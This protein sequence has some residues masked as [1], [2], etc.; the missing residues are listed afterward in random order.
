MHTNTHTP[1]LCQLQASVLHLPYYVDIP[2]P[3]STGAHLSV[4]TFYIEQ[5]TLDDVRRTG[6]PYNMLSCSG[7]AGPFFYL[8]RDTR[9][10]CETMSE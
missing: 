5:N 8:V 2:T 7:V 4:D 3:S 10:L 6:H 1:S 9:G